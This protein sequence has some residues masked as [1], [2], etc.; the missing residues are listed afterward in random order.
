MLELLI[1]ICGQTQG[2]LMKSLSVSSTFVCAVRVFT[3]IFGHTVCVCMCVYACADSLLMCCLYYADDSQDRLD[4]RQDKRHSLCSLV[5]ITSSESF[6]REL[7]RGRKSG[8]NLLDTYYVVIADVTEK[9]ILVKLLA[10]DYVVQGHFQY[11]LCWT[12]IKHD[13]FLRHQ[14]K[15]CQCVCKIIRAHLSQGLTIFNTSAHL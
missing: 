10:S 1:R 9:K 2:N 6:Q 12:A 3:C 14:P 15:E 13:S 7:K 5:D 11:F 4:Q 8:W